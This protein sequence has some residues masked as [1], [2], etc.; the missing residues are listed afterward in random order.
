LKTVA[1]LKGSVWNQKAWDSIGDAENPKN[2]LGGVGAVATSPAAAVAGMML[3]TSGLMGSH[4][5]T[6]GGVA[7]GTAGGALV[8]AGIG[9]QLGGPMGALLGAGIGAVAGFGIGIGEKLFGVETPENEAKRL[10]KQLYGVN[11][12]NAMAKQIVS[13]AQSKYAG[14]V[15]VAVRD[16]DVRKMLELYAQ[17][18]GQ[19]M[20][21]SAA[22]PRGGSLVEQGGNLYQ[23]LGYVNGQAYAFQSPLPVMGLSAGGA[24]T[25]PNPGGPNTAAGAG[26]SLTINLNGQPITPEFVADSALAAQGSAYGRTQQA[27]NLNIPGLMV[28]T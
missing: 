19:K 12:D 7:M 5:G 3:G 26:T 20:P 8:G 22:T 13:L 15:S 25:Y 17:G 10:V 21:L 1:S 23:Q 2:F 6:W 16:P 14:H 9:M 18:T 24:G 28:G 11:I 4:M 27:A